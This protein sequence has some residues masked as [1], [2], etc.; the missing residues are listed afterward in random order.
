MDK[1]K[2]SHTKSRQN[3]LHSVYT[4]LCGLYE[5]SGP[6]NKQHCTTHG[7]AP[8]GSGSYLRPKAHTHTQHLSTPYPNYTTI[9]SDREHKQG[10]G[11]LTHQGRYN[12]HKHKYTLGHQHAQHRT[13]RYNNK[14][15]YQI[16]TTTKQTHIH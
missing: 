6:L 14:H 5:Q 10:G 9:R 2:Q 15:T 1:S 7:N 3:N 16:Q 4:R 13:A 11:H 12:I 8:I